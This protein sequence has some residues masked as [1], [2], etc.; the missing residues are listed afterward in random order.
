M[1]VFSLDTSTKLACDRRKISSAFQHF[2]ALTSST[3]L[4]HWVPRFTEFW[5]HPH[6]R[7][8]HACKGLGAARKEALCVGPEWDQACDAPEGD[9]FFHRD[10]PP[11]SSAQSH[12][13]H[14]CRDT[15]SPA[16]W[17]LML[18]FN[19]CLLFYRPFLCPKQMRYAQNII[20]KCPSPGSRMLKV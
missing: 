6:P 9:L 3:W 15:G 11:V 2:P 18:S 5:C 20:F 17:I 1:N 13:F 7:V 12:P 8:A 4:W 19:Y 16:N 10:H 14:L